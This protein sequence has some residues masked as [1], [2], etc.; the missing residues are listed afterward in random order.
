MR[1]DLQADAAVVGHAQRIVVAPPDAPEVGD[2]DDREL[3]PL[4]GVDRHEPHGVQVLRLERRL[5]LA[6]GQH[7]LLGEVVDERAQVAALLG[8]ELA[9]QAHQLSHVRHPPA[10]V[11]QREE[12][13]GRTRSR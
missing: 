12:R 2:A 3:E 9:R 1:R 7:V 8:L 10:A 6:R 13:R 4:R 11:R 5:A